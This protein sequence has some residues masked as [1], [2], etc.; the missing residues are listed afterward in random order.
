[1]L[2]LIQSF[3]CYN[4]DSG[5][6]CFHLVISFHNADCGVGGEIVHI[7]V[8]V[9]VCICYISPITLAEFNIKL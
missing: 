2:S 6:L 7:K 4:F 5:F 3:I 8:N 1:M 9:C